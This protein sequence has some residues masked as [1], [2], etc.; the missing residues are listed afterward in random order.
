M[1]DAVSDPQDG[2]MQFR[3]DMTVELIR[4][5]AQDADVLFAARVSTLGEQSLGD[6]DQ[7]PTRV[8]RR[9]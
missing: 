6:V 8:G 2:A 7:T 5:A 4:A 9:G 1:N 3:S